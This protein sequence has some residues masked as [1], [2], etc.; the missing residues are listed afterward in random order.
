MHRSG[1]R[2][3]VANAVGPPLRYGSNMRSLHLR[4]SSSVDDLQTSQRA[5]V[6]IG[7][8]DCDGER[9]VTKRP[10]RDGC[11]HV[12]DL[13]CGLIYCLGLSKTSDEKRFFGCIR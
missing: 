10:L 1:K 8:L 13:D 6:L 12:A 4:S 9:P 3:T 2:D 11:Y 7:G 5:G